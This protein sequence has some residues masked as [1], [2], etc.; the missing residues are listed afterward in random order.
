MA[1]KPRIGTSARILDT[2][3]FPEIKT[4][5]NSDR[6]HFYWTLL[7]FFGT[8]TYL[9]DILQSVSPSFAFATYVFGTFIRFIGQFFGYI[10]TFLI[11]IGR[12][13]KYIGHFIY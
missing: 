8:N 9:L 13:F 7:M 10:G 6:N 4:T 2:L 11:Y 1:Y 12:F 3:N 5:N